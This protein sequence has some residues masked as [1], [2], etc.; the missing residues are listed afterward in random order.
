MDHFDRL[1]GHLGTVQLRGAKQFHIADQ[2]TRANA[3][4]ET[5]AAEVVEL[6]YI[7]GYCRWMVLRQIQNASGELDV[8]GGI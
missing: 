3:H 7:A 1:N 2:T 6:G 5:T 4:D 8:F